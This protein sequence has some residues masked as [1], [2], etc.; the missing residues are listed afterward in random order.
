MDTNPRRW[1]GRFDPS[2]LLRHLP[3]PRRLLPSAAGKRVARALARRYS[4]VLLPASQRRKLFTTSAK[5]TLRCATAGQR[6]RRGQ[7]LHADGGLHFRRDFYL[8]QREHDRGGSAARKQAPS[9]NITGRRDERAPPYD[10][11]A[12]A[13]STNEGASLAWIAWQLTSIASATMTAS[14]RRQSADA[15]L[16]VQ[17]RYARTVVV[18]TSAWAGG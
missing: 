1:S 12:V 10:N 16:E 18:S 11:T 2:L 7:R 9:A 8:S 5:A 4:S 17:S 15:M 3:P 14:V 13:A 6:S